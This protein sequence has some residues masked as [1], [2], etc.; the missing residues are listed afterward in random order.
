M[1]NDIAAGEA[2]HEY[3]SLNGVIHAP[4]AVRLLIVYSLSSF[5][6]QVRRVLVV[7]GGQAWVQQQVSLPVR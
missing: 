6:V 2:Q 4:S 7:V 5:A 1:S 3:L